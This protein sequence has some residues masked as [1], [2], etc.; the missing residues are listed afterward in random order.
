MEEKNNKIVIYNTEDGQTRIDVRLEND[1]VWLTQD[2]MAELFDKS[3]STINEHIQNIYS[4][5][6]LILEQTM[7]KFGNSEFSTKTTKPTNFYNLDVIISVGYRVSSFRGTQ[8]RI[9]ATQKLKEYIIKGFVM[10]DDRL[11]EGKVTRGYF[12][13]FEERIRKIR[14]SETNFYQKVR[15]VFA[16]SADYNPRLDYAKQFFATVQNKFHYAITGLTATEIITKRID[17]EKTNMGLTSWKGEVIT[18]SQA[19]I[20]K[21]YLEELELKRLNL[22]VEQFLSFAELQSVE[23][24]AMYMKDWIK[25]LDAFLVLNDKAILGNSGG[26][27]RVAMEHKVRGELDRF[28]KKH[29]KNNQKGFNTILLSVVIALIVIVCGVYLYSNKGHNILSSSNT[30]SITDPKDITDFSTCMNYAK[31]IPK[32]FEIVFAHGSDINEVRSFETD[33]QK[34]YPRAKLKVSTEQDYLDKALERNGGKLKA[35]GALDEYKKGL[36]PQTT[37]SIS[38]SVPITDLISYQSFS[39]FIITTL[40]KYTHVKFQQ[41]TLPTGFGNDEQSFAEQQCDHRYNKLNASERAL[42]DIK[43]ADALI[44]GGIFSSVVFSSEYYDI[45][46]SYASGT[47]S[48]NNGICSDTGVYGL[49]KL[50]D[51]V[52]Q[53]AGSAYCYASES[54][55]AFS[56]PL[57]S[58]PE[59]GFCA[60]STGFSGTT[61]SPTA[62]NKG[63]CV[64]P[65]KI[66]QDISSCMNKGNTARTRWMCVGDIVDPRPQFHIQTIVSPYATPVT[67]KID[68]CKRFK[69]I[70]ADYCFSSIVKANAGLNV[71]GSP[72]AATVCAMV[73]NKNPWFKKDCMDKN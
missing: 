42:E 5:N 31:N 52:T 35:P 1:T 37:S 10:D 67:Q 55:L 45:H 60:D 17:S 47:L 58:N 51:S 22:L 4:E 9:W 16:T 39:D 12:E 13:E 44:R 7:R 72:D 48:L 61:T 23:K 64:A 21:N 62:A 34:A 6:E 59:I 26:V 43:S 30:I 65:I 54:E 53:T 8:F 36:E 20:A 41:N 28:N 68:F 27:S 2:Q 50:V 66:S 56:A 63:Y 38:V 49:K 70:E 73:S 15:D 69:R 18:R 29:M 57:K 14:T 32:N 25:K 33:L 46:A 11:S 3:K 19:E 24:R 40:K 71:N